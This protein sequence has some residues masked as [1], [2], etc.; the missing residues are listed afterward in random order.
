MEQAFLALWF[1]LPVGIANSAPVFA[2]AIPSLKTLEYPMDFHR[3]FRG[4]RIFGSHKTFRGLVAGIIVS[5]AIVLL[6]QY[7]YSQSPWLRQWVAVDYTQ[8]NPLIFGILC[9][10]G[11]LLGDAVESFF[12]RQI[13]VKPGKAWFPF[14]QLD[15]I[16]GG[17]IFTAFYHVL[18]FSVYVWIVVIWFGLHLLSTWIGYIVGLKDSPI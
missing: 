13:G 8:I 15:Y 12:K 11:A 5:I 10:L 18:P 16:I 7:F 9:A 14:D 6:Q 17:M 1:F 4:K 2:K 3:M